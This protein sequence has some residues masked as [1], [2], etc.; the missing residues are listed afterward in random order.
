[1]NL[2]I[3]VINHGHDSM[4]ATNP[5]LGLLAKQFNVIIKSN[6]PA[7][8]TLSHY[9]ESHGIVLLQGSKPKG[10]GANN[11]DVF[12]YVKA[13]LSPRPEDYFLALNPDVEISTES[14]SDLISQAIEYQA[15]ISAI[16]LFTDKSFNTYDRSIR[17]YPSLLSPLKSLIGLPRNDVYDKSSINKPTKIEWAAGSFLLFAVKSFELL[18]GFDENYFMYFE[19]ADIC[20]RANRNGFSVYYFP[21]IKAVH[22]A[23]HQNRR[24]FSKHF[25][26]YWKSSLRYQIRLRSGA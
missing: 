4:I 16:N 7:S 1:M 14:V 21:N 15:D 19:D 2:F 17:R 6:T 20:T 23:S 12:S 26:W 25:I 11:N 24:L 5:T 10:F 22:Y 9:C 18:H 3:S 13:H 8:D